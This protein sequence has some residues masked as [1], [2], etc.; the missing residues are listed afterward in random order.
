MIPPQKLELWY[1]KSRTFISLSNFIT[2]V[3]VLCVLDSAPADLSKLAPG[4]PPIPPDPPTT[5]NKRP[6]TPPPE[7]LE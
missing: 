3:S 4:I 1:A 5:P 2:T 6:I 7:L